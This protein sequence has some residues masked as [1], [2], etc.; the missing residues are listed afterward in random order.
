MEWELNWGSLTAVALPA[1]EKGKRTMRHVGKDVRVL[2]GPGLPALDHHIDS[3]KQASVLKSCCLFVAGL[4][5]KSSHS[6]SFG[7][8]YYLGKACFLDLNYTD[9][10]PYF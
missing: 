6:S 8:K 4:L 1:A 10:S 2:S 9:S 7:L 3:V 5:I